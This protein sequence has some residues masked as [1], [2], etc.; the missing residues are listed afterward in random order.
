[1]PAGNVLLWVI[2]PLICTVALVLAAWRVAL[3][4]RPTGVPWWRR[5]RILAPLAL[6]V[7][8]L[9]LT[10]KAWSAWA[11][12]NLTQKQVDSLDLASLQAYQQQVAD[13]ANAYKPWGIGLVL[14]TVVTLGAVIVSMTNDPP[15]PKQDDDTPASA[16]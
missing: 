9:I 4:Y 5:K 11:P 13:T 2:T 10:I 7:P 3:L 15:I 6:A 14:L 8:A 1:M 12:L 16:Q